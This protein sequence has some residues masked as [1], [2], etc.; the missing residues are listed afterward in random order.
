MKL[1]KKEIRIMKRRCR[2]IENLNRLNKNYNAQILN[3]KVCGGKAFAAEQ[4]V[5]ES[6]K[7]L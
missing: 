6:K 3:L 2:Q 5:I 1:S 7:L 4:K